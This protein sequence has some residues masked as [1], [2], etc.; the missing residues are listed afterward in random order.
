MLATLESRIRRPPDLDDAERIVPL[1]RADLSRP[2]VP[3]RGSTGGPLRV[4][5]ATPDGPRHWA[6]YCTRPAD[7]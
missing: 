3:P 7:R 4:A 2:R 5:L 6:N 1:A